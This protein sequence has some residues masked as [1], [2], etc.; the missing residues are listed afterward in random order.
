MNGLFMEF[1]DTDPKVLSLVKDYS[2]FLK[3]LAQS[4]DTMPCTPG[5]DIKFSVFSLFII[6]F[7]CVMQSHKKFNKS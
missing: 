3:S 4:N 6:K 5:Q 1:I 7:Y 2:I